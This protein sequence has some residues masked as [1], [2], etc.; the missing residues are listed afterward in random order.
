MAFPAVPVAP[1]GMV[2]ERNRALLLDLDGVL[3][4][5]PDDLATRAERAAGLPVGAIHA[6]AF[7]PSLLRRAVTGAIGDAGWR[8]EVAVRLTRDAPVWSALQA[9]AAWSAS[10]G[11]VDE[12]VRGW[13]ARARTAARV[14]LVTN[15]TDRLDADLRALGLL[16]DFDAVVNSSVVGCAKPDPCLV[17]AALA[18]AAVPADRAL[19]VD[20]TAA[21]VAAAVALGVPGHVFV[22]ADGL[23]KTLV[24]HG[25]V[26]PALHRRRA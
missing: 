22:D 19:F 10:P 7:E 18:T 26:R 9:V 11:V 17:R 14:V 23:A 24:E 25:L 6:A 15:A 16:G 4:R 2:D 21:N 8:S 3:R 20:D 5:W 1:C 13:V 12:A